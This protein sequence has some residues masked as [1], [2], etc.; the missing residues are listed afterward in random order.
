MAL[1]NL[2]FRSKVLGEEARLCV[3]LPTRDNGRETVKNGEKFKV[4]YVLHG[5][6]DDST[7]YVRN[8][9]IERYA[10]DCG[11]AVVM[12]EVRLSFYSDMVRGQKYFTYI[13]EEVPYIAENIFPISNKR[14]D[15]YII[16]NS[17]GSHGAMKWALRCPEY[18][19]GAA[20]M[21]GVGELE[22]L[23][24]YT[25]LSSLKNNP[26]KNSFGSVNEYVN[27]ENDL[28]Y[29]AKKLV[30]SGKSIPR[31]FS[32]CGTEDFTYTGVKD[33]V[34]YATKIGLPLE[35]KDGPGVHDWV[36]WDNWMQYI[37]KWFGLGGNQ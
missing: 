7:Y 4:L 30:E 24:F 28:K 23:G 31:L 20:G 1:I 11:F 15:H 18:F 26:V 13:S 34:E 16:G 29:L 12:P 36:F 33:F 9:S 25:R 2:T 35:F 37:I 19:A 21:S 22:E 10:S 8:T 32:C 14:E 6:S 3:I 5:G 17:M 27:S